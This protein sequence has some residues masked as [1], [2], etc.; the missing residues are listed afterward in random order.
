MQR[1]VN[2]WPAIILI[3]ALLL[4]GCAQ[5]QVPAPVSNP[6]NKKVS[7]S[8]PAWE[9]EWDRV[10]QAAREEGRV[11]M[12]GGTTST[13]LKEHAAGLIKQKFGFDFETV[14]A[15]GGEQRARVEAERRR[16]IFYSD[17]AASGVSTMYDLKALGALDPMAQLLL[18]PEVVDASKWLDGK[19]PFGDKENTTLIWAAFP[20]LQLA[21]NTSLVRSGEV[22]SYKDL[23]DP[24]WKGKMIS[25]DPTI[26]GGAQLGFTGNLYNKLVDTDFYHRLVKEQGLTISRDLRLQVEWLAQGKFP[27][28]LHPSQGTVARFMNAGAP[29]ALVELKE[30]TL[31]SGAGAGVSMMNK[32]PH[33]NAARVFIN[34]FL[35]REGQQLIQDAADKQSQRV[36][37][38]TDKIS[39]LR[40]PG[41][42]YVPDPT[43]EEQFVLHE[44][45]KYNVLARE[46]FGSTL[47]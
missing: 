24:R 44:Y 26:P 8:K 18:L 14:T 36:D 13:L 16:G 21:I 32:A 17:V 25:G 11:V 23:L 38:S 33:P 30:G 15:S 47:K 27:L 19:L 22:T 28:L 7:V 35:S 42:N 39:A 2:P 4:A 9:V 29:V 34:W 12:Y 43:N 20:N 41:K 6:E 45:S 31:L 37:T 40:Q 1:N 46:L 3:A 10:L 5:Q